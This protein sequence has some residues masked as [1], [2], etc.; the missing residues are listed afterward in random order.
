MRGPIMNIKNVFFLSFLAFLSLNLKAQSWKCLEKSPGQYNRKYCYSLDLNNIESTGECSFR[1]YKHP[2]LSR[3]TC[4][5]SQ[6]ELWLKAL[7]CKKSKDV[8]YDKFY[9]SHLL[10]AGEDHQYSLVTV[11]PSLYQNE[12]TVVR[13]GFHYIELY[14]Y[15]GINFHVD[16]DC[17]AQL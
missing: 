9:S 4:D 11:I 14:D 16:M 15:M 2:F 8:V 6:K 7:T 10:E 1:I 13:S 5:Q 17:K 3:H 12:G